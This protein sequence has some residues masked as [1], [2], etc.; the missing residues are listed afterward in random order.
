MNDSEMLQHDA[1][2]RMVWAARLLDNRKRPKQQRFRFAPL[3]PPLVNRRQIDQHRL[4]LDAAGTKSTLAQSQRSSDG[5]F[6][7][8]VIAVTAVNRA[9]IA[10]QN[11]LV[12]GI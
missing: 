3:L 1:D 4:E 12:W 6:S 9:E 7:K 5:L 8:L 11:G 2:L 10:K